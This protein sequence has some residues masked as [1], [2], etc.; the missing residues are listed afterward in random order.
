MTVAG[1]IIFSQFPRSWPKFRSVENQAYTA[2]QGVI[3][4]SLDFVK[5]THSSLFSQ[6]VKVWQ[7]SV[8]DN[9]PLQN[10]LHVASLCLGE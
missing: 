7:D 10:F 4:G 3:H 5:V 8:M 9:L 6:S 1:S 2:S